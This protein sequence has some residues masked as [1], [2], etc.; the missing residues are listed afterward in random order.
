MRIVVLILLSFPL[1]ANQLSF[2]QVIDRIKNKDT[3][4]Y[5]RRF[6]LKAAKSERAAGRLG[7]LPTL[8]LGHELNRA[9]KTDQ[10]SNRSFLSAGLNIFKGGSDYYALKSSALRFSRAKQELINTEIETEREAINFLVEF[11]KQKNALE[12]TKRQKSL[13]RDIY[14]AVS[15]RFEQGLGPKQERDKAQV[16]ALNA[17][18]QV[19]QSEITMTQAQGNILQLLDEN[20]DQFKDDTKQNNTK[21]LSISSAWPWEDSI[22][23]MKVEAIR[24][25]QYYEMVRPRTKALRFDYE[26]EIESSKGNRSL[27]IPQINLTYTWSRQEIT[28][29]INPFLVGFNQSDQTALLSFSFPLF[30]Q[31]KDVATYKR[32]KARLATSHAQLI[33]AKREDFAQ[34]QSIKERLISA[35]YTVKSRVETLKLGK[36]IYQTSYKRFRAGRA[37]V[38]DLAIDQNRLFQSENLANEGMAQFHLLLT[39]FCHLQGKLINECVD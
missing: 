10:E 2:N 7:F 6:D 19:T 5:A 13:A 11:I 21:K 35:L 24:N 18:A 9:Y 4:L 22:K 37:T 36:S 25:S 12:I 29:N 20:N 38:N 28:K 34:W 30:N 27:F 16:D 32:Q 23:T 33:E 15:N 8:D 39:E 1:S 31:Y 26:S 17:Q 14:S 3:N